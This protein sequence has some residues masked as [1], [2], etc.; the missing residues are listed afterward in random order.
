VTRW[1]IVP[2]AVLTF[3][4]AASADPTK[5][6]CLDANEKAQE[7]R[8]SG[9]FHSAR[10]QLA[11]CGDAA[12][13][14]LLRDDCAK[15]L[16]DIATVQPSIVFF[17]KDGAG[18]DVDTVKVSADG[19]P[20]ADKLTGAA[21]EVDPGDHVFRFEGPGGVVTERWLVIQ[22]GEKGRNETVVLQPSRTEVA[23][24]PSP[25]GSAQR[26]VA[27]VVGGVGVAGIVAGS[28][29]GVVALSS[30]PEGCNSM[31]LCPYK[32]ASNIS[33][34]KGEEAA[35]D[36]SFFVGVLC[37]LSGGVLLATAPSGRETVGVAPWIGPGSAGVEGRF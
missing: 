23:A 20:L 24:A 31:G 26:T 16:A 34:L 9:A 32:D 10:A 13:S 3:S 21:L 37:F 2:L 29:F 1:S 6:A 27:Y 15:R 7:L 33:A 4:A 22:E 11:I 28:I 18:K 36:V 35:A 5:E 17:A 30:K 19:A 12:C 25:T 8:R 14:T